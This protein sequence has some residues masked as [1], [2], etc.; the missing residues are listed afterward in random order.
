[1]RP[2]HIV[3]PQSDIV[4]PPY[5]GH[6][7]VYEKTLRYKECPLYTDFLSLK[8]LSASFVFSTLGSVRLA[9]I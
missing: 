5:S 4:K 1:M 6:L 2:S 7:Y 3:E 9:A 8:S